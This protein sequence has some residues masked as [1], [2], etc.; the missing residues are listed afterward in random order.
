MAS[1]FGDES[2]DETQK[3]VFAIACVLGTDDEWSDLVGKWTTR[4]DGKT[5]HAAT[6]ESE[7]ANDPDPDKHKANLR[8][9]K[10]L[11]QLIVG[12][13]LYGWGVGIDMGAF[14]EFFP[15]SPKDIGYYKCLSETVKRIID[16]GKRRGDSELKFTF[17][18]RQ[19]SDATTA[20]L[21][22]WMVNQPEWWGDNIF[23]DY[24]ISFSSIK[25]PRIQVADLVARETMKHLEN[26][27]KPIADR[28][29]TRRSMHALATTNNRFQFDFLVRSYFRDWASK[30]GDLAK[31]VDFTEQDMRQW[32]DANRLADTMGNRLRFLV[33]F[34]SQEMRRK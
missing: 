27:L 29:V 17:D 16:E 15:E 21:Y 34:D 12:S 1:V 31:V 28:R 18:N 7:F 14:L 9:Y 13:G 4:T 11:I 33:W 20:I 32:F 23:L 25:N 3:R 6:C 2:A 5:F 30:M 19:Q 10:D 24:E 8:L 26:E 22:D